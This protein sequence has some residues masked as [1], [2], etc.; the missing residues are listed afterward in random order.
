MSGA[1]SYEA[2]S[3]RCLW[4][5]ELWQRMSRRV[6]TESKGRIAVCEGDVASVAQRRQE[7]QRLSSKL[8]RWYLGR[9][10]ERREVRERGNPKGFQGNPP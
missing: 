7:A 1:Y 6:A 10:K 3:G 8:Q 9:Q 5:S 2:M 4:E